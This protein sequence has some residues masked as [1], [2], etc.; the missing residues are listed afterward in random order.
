M[1][2]FSSWELFTCLCCSTLHLVKSL[3]A[4]CTARDPTATNIWHGGCSATA[5]R[6]AL[7]L[8]QRHQPLFPPAAQAPP[9]AALL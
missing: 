6:S 9:P 2:V 4:C 8:Q 1:V 5:S 7:G 3:D